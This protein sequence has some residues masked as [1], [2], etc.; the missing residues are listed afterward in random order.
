MQPE[1]NRSRTLAMSVFGVST[2]TPTAS[3][4]T[5][6]EPDGGQQQIEVVNHQVEDHVHVEAAIGK[7]AEPVDFDEARVGDERQ[8]RRHRRVEPLGVSDGAGDAAARGRLDDARRPRPPTTASGFSTSTA[9]PASMQPSAISACDSVGTA[10][11][12]ASTR[13]RTSRQSS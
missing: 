4:S 6:S 11:V 7:R 2:F 5:T 13:P 3:M 8:R 10:I 9:T 12:T 1:A